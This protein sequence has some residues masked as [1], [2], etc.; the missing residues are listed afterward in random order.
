M[1][2]R[3]T[4]RLGG[5]AVGR[6]GDASKDMAK[7]AEAGERQDCASATGFSRFLWVASATRNSVGY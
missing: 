1:S 5:V 7:K 6:Q 3:D 4:D 2:F